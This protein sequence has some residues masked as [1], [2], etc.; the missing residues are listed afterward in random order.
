MADLSTVRTRVLTILLVLVVVLLPFM[1]CDLY[2]GFN[3]NICLD[4]K[5]QNFKILF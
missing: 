4:E 2:Y 5:I 3:D 1:I